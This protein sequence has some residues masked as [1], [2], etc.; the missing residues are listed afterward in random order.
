MILH[1]IEAG[2]GDEP[3]V[4][5]HGLFGSATN[6]ATVQR[7][8][9]AEGSR[10]LAMDL[11]NHGSS[12][13][14]RRMSYPLMALDVV[15]TLDAHGL[16]RVAL[17]GHSMGGKTAMQ[18]ALTEPDRVTRLIVVDIAPVPYEPHYRGYAAA[19]LALQLPPGLTRAEASEELAPDVPDAA[20]RG[21]LLQNLRFGG[22]PH[23]RIGLEEIAGSLP[24][25][26][27][28]PGPSESPYEGPTLVLRGERSD[29]VLP[30]H[31][32]VFRAAFPHARFVTIRGAGHLVHAEAPEAFLGAV[33]AFLRPRDTAA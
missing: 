3:L 26:E 6:F 5:L 18:I 11:R 13:H 15:E 14:D 29:Y 1:T 9:A 16:G 20:M 2:E 17:L 30:E 27:A 33:S 8:L 4:L 25:I 23:W 7:R 28:W 10:V 22:T 21:F 19:M 12:P 31:R 24:S 32:P